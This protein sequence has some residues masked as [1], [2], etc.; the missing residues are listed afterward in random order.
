MYC[1]I[2]GGRLVEIRD[3][4]S[5]WAQ[6]YRCST[7]NLH[8]FMKIIDARWIFPLV[9]LQTGVADA[10]ERASEDTLRLAF[11]RIKQVDYRTVSLLFF[12]HTL[13]GCYD[14]AREYRVVYPDGSST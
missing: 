4:S 1:S 2:C 10:L 3:L 12:E 11:S 6:A 8:A 14:P 7:S 5:H 13:L 9:E